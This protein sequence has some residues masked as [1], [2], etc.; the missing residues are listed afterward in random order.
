MTSM[1]RH[2]A[3]LLLIAYSFLAQKAYSEN[4]S[5]VDFSYLY[6]DGPLKMKHKIAEN[7]GTYKLLL[8]FDLK[9]VTKDDDIRNFRLMSQKK[10][11]SGKEEII[12]PLTQYV[13]DENNVKVFDLTFQTNPEHEYLVIKLDFLADPYVFDIPIGPGLA[14]PLPNF[15]HKSADPN[16]AI[17]KKSDSLIFEKMGRGAGKYF[18][19]LYKDHFS[20]SFPAFSTEVPDANKRFVIEK[21]DPAT[22]GYKIPNENYMYYFQNDTSS[23]KGVSFYSQKEYFPRNK[24]FDELIGPLIYIATEN[25]FKKLETARNKKSAF[26]DFWLSLIPSQK[27]AARTLRNYFRRVAQANVNFTSYKNGW[28]TDMGMIYILYGAPDRVFKDED[29]EIW[30]YSNYD[31]KVRFSFT[32]VPNLFTQYHYSLERSKSYTSDW[33]SQIERWR[34][35][36][37]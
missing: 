23:Q 14:Y 32:K 7:E 20:P 1:T 27:L 3:V 16:G 5:K 33:F 26:D 35:G 31:G 15:V 8:Y 30:E 36:D 24:E 12:E 17:V 29:A 22:Y 21:V 4:L 37:S 25:E 34:K 6:K 19:F 18:G 11:T 10:F 9:K 2:A 28:K 13:S